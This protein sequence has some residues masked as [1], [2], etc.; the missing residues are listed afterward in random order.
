MLCY[1]GKDR[2]RVSRVRAV[3]RVMVNKGEGLVRVG[4]RARARAT[5]KAKARARARARARDRVG[6]G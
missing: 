1:R 2:G 5:A 6:Y 3:E 4:A